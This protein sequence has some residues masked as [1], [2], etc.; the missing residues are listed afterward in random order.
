MTFLFLFFLKHDD[1]KRENLLKCILFDQDCFYDLRVLAAD[2]RQNDWSSVYL[3]ELERSPKNAYMQSLEKREKLFSQKADIGVLSKLDLEILERIHVVNVVVLGST[4][5]GLYL[6]KGFPIF[7]R[8]L[9]EV[10]KS[11][12]DVVFEYG[13]IEILQNCNRPDVSHLCLTNTNYPGYFKLKM[14]AS[15]ME[16][17]QESYFK[18]TNLKLKLFG[19]LDCMYFYV[20]LQSIEKALNSASI[21]GNTED[22]LGI[23]EMDNVPAFKMKEWPK[24]ASGFL[25]RERKSGWPTEKLLRSATSQGC[26]FVTKGVSSSGEKDFHWRISFAASEKILARSLSLPQIRSYLFFKSLCK[27]ML[28]QPEGLTSYMLKNILFW[29]IET[30]DQS[31]WRDDNVLFCVKALLDKLNT[32]LEQGVIAS[33]FLP[34]LNLI[35]NIDRDTLAQLSK[36]ART[37]QTDP[38]SAIVVCTSSN[39]FKGS[40]FVSVSALKHSFQNDQKYIG[41]VYSMVYFT[42]YLYLRLQ[43]LRYQIRLSPVTL[44]GCF[45]NKCKSLVCVVAPRAAWYLLEAIRIQPDTSLFTFK[46]RGDKQYDLIIE[47][48]RKKVV[49]FWK[50]PI[51]KGLFGKVIDDQELVLNEKVTTIPEFNEFVDWVDMTCLWDSGLSINIHNMNFSTDLD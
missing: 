24:V 28:G 45:E 16:A 19:D 41:S 18:N 25:S 21:V 6:E 47:G 40:C 32:C 43:A 26:G 29:T 36:K 14:C 33:Y 5:D 20:V 38:C 46:F 42:M 17:S 30:I 49:E 2:I 37:V 12:V 11:D 22:E 13:G 50:S 10:N 4:Q 35:N 1:R 39:D 23:H 51:Y 9:L 3:P 7:D 44:R 48:L 8:D 34:D 27:L 15:Q 31:A